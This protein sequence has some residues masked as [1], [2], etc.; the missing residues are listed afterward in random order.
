MRISE[1]IELGMHAGR[2]GGV[3]RFPLG[4]RVAPRPAEPVKDRQ[5][6]FARLAPPDS[7]FRLRAYGMPNRVVSHV[8]PRPFSVYSISSMPHAVAASRSNVAV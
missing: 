6:G 1:V 7:L 3:K 4:I 8:C 2:I 5:G